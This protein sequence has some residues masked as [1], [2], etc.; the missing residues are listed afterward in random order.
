M[1]LQNP[2]AIFPWIQQWPRLLAVQSLMTIMVSKLK[3]SNISYLRTRKIIRSALVGGYISSQEG[4]CFH[5]IFISSLHD[6]QDKGA[7]V[8]NFGRSVSEELAN[9]W[10]RWP[11]SIHLKKGQIRLGALNVDLRLNWIDVHRLVL[12]SSYPIHVQ[13]NSFQH[14][15]IP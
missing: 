10:R 14:P 5:V 11:D 3:G 9:L 12:S 13:P 7:K 2:S 1:A 6:W 15:K 4:I 8:V